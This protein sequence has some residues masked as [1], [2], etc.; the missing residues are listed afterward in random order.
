MK[1]WS[2]ETFRHNVMSKYLKHLFGHM[3]TFRHNVM[4]NYLKLFSHYS[5]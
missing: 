4:Q 3:K 1:F 5:L 2:I